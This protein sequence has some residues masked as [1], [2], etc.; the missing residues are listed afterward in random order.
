MGG[1][2]SENLFR[3][4]F[5]NL[6]MRERAPKLGRNLIEFGRRDLEVVV[7]NFQ[8]NG[9]AA[10]LRGGVLKWPSSDIAH[11]KSPHEFKAR[12]PV[13]AVPVPVAQDE[14]F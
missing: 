3:V 8:T 7:S 11:P 13:Q 2:C 1:K 10:G 4:P 12:K 6:E 9:S 14:V 5:G